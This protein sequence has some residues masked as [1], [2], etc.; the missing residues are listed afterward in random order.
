M[1]GASVMC[2]APTCNATTGTSTAASFCDGQ[3]SCPAGTTKGCSPFLCGSTACQTSC[4]GTGA[5]QCVSSA[6]CVGGVCQ[7]CASGRSACGNVCADETSDPNHCGSCT[8]ACGGTTPLCVSSKC[9]QCSALTDCKTGYVACTNNACVCRAKAAKNLM[10]NAGFDSN[11]SG[12]TSAE[13][14][15]TWSGSDADGCPASG[16]LTAPDGDTLSY[17]VQNVLP[18]TTYYFGY[19][20]VQ[21]QAGAINC[22]VTWTTDTACQSG[23]SRF[24][25]QSGTGTGTAWSSIASS[26]TSS[27]GTVA[28]QILCGVG[29]NVKIDQVYLNTVISGF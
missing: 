4:S 19:K 15:A 14:L 17:C 13:N 28:A 3:G 20:Y 27:A 8:T 12:W 22:V 1:P 9:V 18:N 29:G 16:S 7:T 11:V 5:N 10:Q 24:F 26:A 6:A 2:S 23:L 21:D 25:V